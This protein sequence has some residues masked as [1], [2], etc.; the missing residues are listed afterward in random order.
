M[1]AIA[2]DTHVKRVTN[3]LGLMPPGGEDDPVKIERR[4]RQLYDEDR[5]AGISMRVIQFGRDICD[6]RKPQCWECPLA[7]RCPYPDKTPPP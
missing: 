1:P 4:L 2:V 5:W 7:D 6:A 3:R